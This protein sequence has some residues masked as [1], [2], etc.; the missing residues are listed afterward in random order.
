[1]E[2]PLRSAGR[3]SFVIGEERRQ[4]GC[5]SI[6]KAIKFAITWPLM[7]AMM[8]FLLLWPLVVISFLAGAGLMG[9][10]M[11]HDKQVC[12]Q[13]I[14]WMLYYL[15]FAIFFLRVGIYRHYMVQGAWVQILERI[16]MCCRSGKMLEVV[17]VSDGVSDVILDE[18]FIRERHGNKSVSIMGAYHIRRSI[19]MTMTR[20]LESSAFASTHGDCINSPKYF[21]TG[22]GGSSIDGVEELWTTHTSVC[23]WAAWYGWCES[24]RVGRISIPLQGND[25]V[26]GHIL[27][28]ETAEPLSSD[29]LSTVY[30]LGLLPSCCGKNHVVQRRGYPCKNCF[31]NFEHGQPDAFVF[32]EKMIAETG[33][34]ITHTFRICARA[35]IVDEESPP[36]HVP[37]SS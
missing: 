28:L 34:K 15:F 25:D 19:D 29:L 24:L 14:F 22:Q 32:K 12:G 27:L 35:T 2:T 11:V 10:I 1:M 13:C 31:G 16:F 21:L 30:G 6:V 36:V 37:N 9:Y 17:H 5:M 3:N 7:V 20:V 18:D 23:S 33:L 8:L 4:C 26:L